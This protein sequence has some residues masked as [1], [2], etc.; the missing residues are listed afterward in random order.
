MQAGG[1]ARGEGIQAEK[2]AGSKVKRAQAGSLEEQEEPGGGQRAR[3]GGREAGKG[4]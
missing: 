4:G 3:V 1:Q 2:A